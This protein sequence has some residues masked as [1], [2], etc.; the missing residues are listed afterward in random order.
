MFG[1][2]RNQ[3]RQMFFDT[4][5]KYQDK[6]E[7]EPLEQIICQ[8]IIM[9]PE[10]HSLLDDADANLQKEYFSEHGEINP[11]LHMAM[12]ISIQEQLATQRPVGI[13]ALHVRLLNKY[14][15]PHVSEHKMM[16]CLSEMIW[17]SQQSG[18]P[19]DDQS[20]LTC[21]EKLAQS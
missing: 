19:P 9:H 12:H 5:K 1:N 10:Y 2:D 15:D 4:W 6:L 7:L 8:I 16:E 14:S 18:T 3:L 17:Q 11:F 13:N 21:L 20:Y